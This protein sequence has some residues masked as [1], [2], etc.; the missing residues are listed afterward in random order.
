MPYGKLSRAGVITVTSYDFKSTVDY[1]SGEDGPEIE[2]AKHC[3]VRVNPC[4]VAAGDVFPVK[5][6]CVNVGSALQHH[7]ISQ[8]LERI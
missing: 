2:A 8:E 6:S 3:S 7:L 5:L 4:K 1:L